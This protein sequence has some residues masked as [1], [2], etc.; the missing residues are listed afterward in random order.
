MKR[1]STF[2][3]RLKELRTE[4]KLSQLQ[5][6]EEVGISKTNIGQ[7]EIGRS[8]ALSEAVVKLAIFFEVTTDYLLG[9]EE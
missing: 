7:W 4:R 5:L 8:D 6:A 2:A 1:V 9:F 3:K